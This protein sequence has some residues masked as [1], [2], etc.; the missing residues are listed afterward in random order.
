MKKICLSF[1]IYLLP[2]LYYFSFSQVAPDILF[3]N[4]QYDLAL[5]YYLRQLNLDSNDIELNIKTGKCFYESRS[6][7]DKAVPYLEKAVHRIE[8][9]NFA[10]KNKLYPLAY[11]YLGDAYFHY[12]RFKRA[13]DNY[14]DFIQTFECT[15]GDQAKGTICGEV[16]SRIDLCIFGNEIAG[17]IDCPRMQ[18]DQVEF[19]ET[20]FLIHNYRAEEIKA[21]KEKPAIQFEATLGTSIDGQQVLIYRN[22]A[23]IAELYVISLS[24][25]KWDTVAVINRPQNTGGWEPGEYIND[26]NSKMYF[27]SAVNGHDG[28]NIYVCD[29]LPDNTWGIARNLGTLI[30][31]AYDEEAP[32]IFPGGDLLVF[33]SNKNDSGGY[34]IFASNFIKGSWSTPWG[35]GYPVQG[36]EDQATL[37]NE[38]PTPV[39]KTGFS[40]K[41]KSVSVQIE[42]DSGSSGN[43]LLSFTGPEKNNILVLTGKIVN[44]TGIPPGQSWITVSDN[45]AGVVIN[46][47][48][49]DHSGRYAII[50]PWRKN[51]NLTFGSDNCIFHS[52]N[53]S[54]NERTN[55]FEKRSQ[56]IL[57]PCKTGTEIKLNNIF[58]RQGSETPDS[59]SVTELRNISEL[60]KANPHSQFEIINLVK[61][62]KKKVKENMASERSRSVI[63]WLVYYGASEKQLIARGSTKIS[64]GKNEGCYLKIYENP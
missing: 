48:I 63:E 54:F 28:K 47:Y 38:I 53:I 30:N 64:K 14:R 15:S 9:G 17:S 58:F 33:S 32:F 40:D 57:M 39:L 31:S 45:Q 52:E 21:K 44:W 3:K 1:I 12:H 26:E 60:I 27:A 34:E 20:G 4:G 35:I 18:K 46:K 50:L 56:I 25:N 43:Y 55:Y 10:T 13:M 6:Q 62:G 7:K 59:I 42:E 8:S 24:S 36:K 23:G 61:S 16:N 29:K 51:L 5:K 49:I 22:N 37:Q 2:R 11:K 41:E 19:F